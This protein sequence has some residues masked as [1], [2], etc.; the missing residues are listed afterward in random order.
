MDAQS[1]NGSV[2]EST[3]FTE[4]ALPHG[5]AVMMV[6][7]GVGVLVAIAAMLFAILLMMVIRAII[8]MVLVR[9]GVSGVCIVAALV[10]ALATH[11]GG[12]SYKLVWRIFSRSCC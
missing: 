12:A 8:G 1:D 4:A 5:E 10:L 6:A 9:V 7:R 11:I 2:N 3:S